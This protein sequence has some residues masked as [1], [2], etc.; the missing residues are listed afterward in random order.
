MEFVVIGAALQVLFDRATPRASSVFEFFRRGKLATPLENFRS[1]LITVQSLLN[2]AEDKQLVDPR[3][4]NWLHL[5]KDALYDAEDIADQL[6]TKALRSPMN[7]RSRRRNVFRKVWHAISERTMAS[8]LIKI[9]ERLNS[10]ANQGGVLGLQGGVLPTGGVIPV[11]STTSFMEESDVYGRDQEKEGIIASLLSCDSDGGGSVSVIGIVGMGGIGKTTLAQLVYND[12]RIKD[13]FDVMAWVC[14]SDNFDAVRVTRMIIE[15][16]TGSTCSMDNFELLQTQ[17]R[18]MLKDKKFL[19]VLDD[20]WSHGQ[21]ERLST[22]FSVGAHGSKIITTTRNMD[23]ANGVHASPTFQLELLTD[24]DGWSLFSRHALSHEERNAHP[25]LEPIGRKIVEKCKGLPLSIKALAGVLHS[26]LDVKGWKD[27]LVSD[28]WELPQINEVVPALRLSYYHLPPHHKGCFA[29]C[30]MF[31]KDHLFQRESLVRL[32]MAKNFI[33]LEPGS[34]RGLEDVGDGCFNNLLSRSFF[35]PAIR[36]NIS[37]HVMHDLFHDLAQL[38]SRNSCFLLEENKDLGLDDHVRHMSYNAASRN[39]LY[40]LEEV[41]AMKHL[42]TF[43]ALSQERLSVEAPVYIL[44]HFKFLRVLSLVGYNHCKLPSTIGK[45]EYLRYLDVSRSAIVELPESICTLCNLQ[46]LL[47]FECRQL[48]G[49]PQ[50]LWKLISLRHL[51]ISYT[52][53]RRMPEHMGRLKNLRTLTT[54]VVSEDGAS[55]LGELNS[56]EHLVGD[57]SLEGLQNVAMVDDAIGANLHEKSFLKKLRLAFGDGTTHIE[58]E[59]DVLASLRP[60]SQIHELEISKY[61]GTSFPS[62]LMGDLPFA[63]MVNLRL[64]DCRNCISLPRLGQL[65]C[66]RSLVICGMD[67]LQKIGPDFY[68][69]GDPFPSLQEMRFESMKSWELWEA[70]GNGVVDF[71]TLEVL[72]L[73]G[74]PKLRGAVPIQFPSLRTLALCRC[75][76]LADNLDQR[77]SAYDETLSSLTNLTLWSLAC[78]PSQLIGLSSLK[79]L[80]IGAVWELKQLPDVLSPNLD[81]LSILGAGFESLPKSLVETSLRKMFISNCLSLKLC[82]DD[83]LPTSLNFL[84]AVGGGAWNLE[85]GRPW[86]NMRHFSSLVKL[87]LI[88]AVGLVS[89]PLGSFLNLR[90]IELHSCKELKS[91]SL[92]E[93]GVDQRG[94]L[95]CLVLLVIKSCPEL[96]F[97]GRGGDSDTPNLKFLF[98]DDCMKLKSLPQGMLKSVSLEL[99]LIWECPGLE[100]IPEGTLPPSLLTL[101]LDSEELTSGWSDRWCLRATCPHLEYLSICLKTWECFPQ[102]ENFL[103]TGLTRLHIVSCTNLKKLDGKGLQ[104]LTSLVELSIRGCSL[105]QSLPKEGLPPSVSRLRILDCPKLEASCRRKGGKDWP[106]ISRIPWIQLGKIE[107]DTD[108]DL[109]SLLARIR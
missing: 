57:L 33:P 43:F 16:G 62:W 27:V 36:S 21:W 2:D 55:T 104:N 102:K 83:E 67:H 48:Q 29:Y 89:F 106:K 44:P 97:V 66:L 1:T 93:E 52:K 8:R 85:V 95:I 12:E 13:R 31:P 54:Y 58:R 18:G 11:T 24:E 98:I 77:F 53:V 74:C 101:C 105:L 20:M 4:R 96:E 35:Q 70:S 87:E 6:S 15:C 78:I 59:Q 39:N 34:R 56:F 71:P 94:G 40:Q 25:E 86:R 90:D 92:S 108:E 49:L 28:I 46:T 103:P 10:F 64:S 61:A 88:N 14:V 9:T 37:G 45:L 63:K 26:N 84:R 100:P 51:D 32:W 75:D 41:P 68:G 79:S 17:L 81:V 72:T 23:V 109:H 5:L 19:M 69:N 91:I 47:L 76:Q 107:L 3:V 80:R 30:A 60:P 7:S 65:A 22:P 82:P 38:I 73:E 42:R 99:L 50:D